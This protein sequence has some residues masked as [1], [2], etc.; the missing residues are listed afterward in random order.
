MKRT[1]RDLIKQKHLD[2]VPAIDDRESMD[3]ALRL[4]FE[5]ECGALLVTR[6][7]TPVGIFSERDFARYAT[8]R[9]PHDPRN[10]LVSAAMSDSVIYVAPESRLDECLA[11]MDGHRI[12]H[13]LVM[14]LGK[15]V[16]LLSM[17]HIVGALIEDKT[18]MIEELTR[19]ISGPYHREPAEA[20]AQLPNWGAAG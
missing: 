7:G 16:A 19:Y 9:G 15:P 4:L 18:F 3:T 1:V 10:H 14:E 2:K 13:L 8:G 20:P 17:R 5:N 6:D 12:R 11:I